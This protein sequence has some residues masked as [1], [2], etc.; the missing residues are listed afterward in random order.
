MTQGVIIPLSVE[1]FK[2]MLTKSNIEAIKEYKKTVDP[3]S[4]YPDKM[5]IPMAI[6]MTGLSRK[7]I[8]NKS[9]AG[10][11]KKEYIGNK[12][13]FYKSELIPYIKT[14]IKEP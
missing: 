14:L 6:K 2:E 7:T 5:S 4:G 8:Y 3:Y 9:N 1:A 13:Y 12:P 11:L 10:F